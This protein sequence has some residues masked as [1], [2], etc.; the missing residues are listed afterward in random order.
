MDPSGLVIGDIRL[1]ARSTPPSPDNGT[2]RNPNDDRLYHTLNENE[3]RI[4]EV[5]PGQEE[6][7]IKS[8][9]Q[10]VKLGNLTSNYNALSYVWGDLKKPKVPLVVN[11]QLLEV[12]EN[13][14]SALKEL[15]RDFM[16][17]SKTCFIWIDAICI[18]QMDIPERN[19]QL[20]AMTRIYRSSRKLIVWL[21][22]E[23]DESH[24]A[25]SVMEA[26]PADCGQ[27]DLERYCESCEF[28]PECLQRWRSIATFFSRPWFSRVWIVQE[29][30]A[31]SQTKISTMSEVASEDIEFYCGTSRV[32]PATLAK[33]L[34]HNGFLDITKFDGPNFD[35]EFHRQI[36]SLY[37]PFRRGVKCFSDILQRAATPLTFSSSEETAH[38]FLRCIVRGFEYG[39]TEPRDR[40]YAHL[41]LQFTWQGNVEIL[42]QEVCLGALRQFVN[43][44][45]ITRSPIE[46][47]GERFRHDRLNFSELIVDYNRSVEDVYSSLVS[48]MVYA[49][50]SL[51]VL[52]LCYGRSS[53]V[54]RTWTP[55]LTSASFDEKGIPQ[56][57]GLLTY[58]ILNPPSV[59]SFLASK[60][61]TAEAHFSSDL[62]VLSVRGCRVATIAMPMGYPEEFRPEFQ[63]VFLEKYALKALSSQL[64]DLETYETLEVAQKVVWETMLAGSGFENDPEEFQRWCSWLDTNSESCGIGVWDRVICHQLHRRVFWVGDKRIGK[65]WESIKPGDYV[66]VILGCDV[67]LV[68]RP[69]GDYYELIGD[70]YI[71]G[72]MEGEAMKDFE[73]RKIELETFRLH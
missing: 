41:P 34:R 61:A 10:H 59:K 31:C 57:G 67:P 8:K 27:R 64:V 21:G 20:L 29:Y 51:N 33:I 1:G 70:C 6:D 24:E 48:F 52:S 23:S 54:R 63:S 72:I 35:I 37:I 66:C 38:H 9:L 53:Q 15:R 73:D 30:L 2:P 65:G 16:A 62:S 71:D 28:N 5:L 4:L 11:E 56:A 49:T 32:S 18:N 26:L 40:V 19:Q 58:S 44:Q 45:T 39:A 46:L 69:V 47:L 3:I 12:T 14:I 60:G 42:M 50:K 7:M 17:R 36:N 55:D 68:L 43:G 25:I 22:L 13:C